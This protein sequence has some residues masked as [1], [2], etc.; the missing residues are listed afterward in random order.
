MNATEFSTELGKRCELSKAEAERLI[1]ETVSLIT[2][3]LQQNNTV[4][5]HNLGSLE[6]KKRA[7]RLT[8][9]P[10]TGKRLLIPPKLVVGYKVQ[11]SLK[12]KIKKISQS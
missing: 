6:V 1:N 7:E 3:L 5:L 10:S 11:N 2:Q 8:V 4:S 12:E 9:N